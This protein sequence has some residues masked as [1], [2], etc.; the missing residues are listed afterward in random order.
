M[1]ISPCLKEQGNVQDHE[2]MPLSITLLQ[3]L[4]PMLLYHGVHN[5]FQLV[6]GI[7]QVAAC[8]SAHCSCGHWLTAI[9]RALQL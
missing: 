1:I 6:H 9:L 3:E 7:L 8:R 4:L 2:A 5:H